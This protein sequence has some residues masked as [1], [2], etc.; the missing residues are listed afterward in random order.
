MRS[1]SVAW[2]ESFCHL[3]GLPTKLRDAGIDDSQFERKADAR[4]KDAGTSAPAT[5][6]CCLA[7]KTS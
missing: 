1:W 7:K 6:L 4:W 2:L 3:M 5:A